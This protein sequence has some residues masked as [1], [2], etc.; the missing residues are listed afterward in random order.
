VFNGSCDWKGA[1]LTEHT[2]SNPIYLRSSRL[3]LGLLRYLF[4]LILFRSQ[5]LF[6]FISPMRTICFVHLIILAY[7]PNYIHLAEQKIWSSSLRYSLLIILLYFIRRIKRTK[8]LFLIASA[9]SNK[10]DLRPVYFQF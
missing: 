8:A 3:C 2:P 10:R 9:S 5:F 4:S 7:F 1:V 6:T